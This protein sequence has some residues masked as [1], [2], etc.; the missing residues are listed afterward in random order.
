M[1]TRSRRRHNNFQ[2]ATRSATRGPGRSRARSRS[3]ASGAA[4]REQIAA[5]IAA[6]NLAFAP[7]GKLELASL[8]AKDVPS[9]GLLESKGQAPPI[10]IE[11]KGCGCHTAGDSA[12]GF[13]SA[14]FVALVLLRRRRR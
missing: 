4:R 10:A 14:G 11:H 3:A 12:G 6:T 8:L 2:A 7:R 1:S 13:A 5:P 9:A